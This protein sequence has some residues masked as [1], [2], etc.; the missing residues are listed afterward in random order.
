MSE[1]FCQDLC[2]KEK[3]E[4]LE[5]NIV[6][7]NG[8]VSNLVNTVNQLLI[9][10]DSLENQ[11]NNHIDTKVNSDSSLAH[12]YD[13]N[14]LLNLDIKEEQFY[15]IITSR[16]TLEGESKE[17]EII[18]DKDNDEF[19]LNAVISGKQLY[20]SLYQQGLDT[21]IAT[22]DLPF[23]Y[24]S[25]FDAHLNTNVNGQSDFAHK[26]IPVVSVQ[27]NLYD[28]ND[29][30][31]LTTKV[32]I[33]LEFDQDNVSLPKS[34]NEINIDGSV[35]GK[36]LYLT[37]AT[38]ND[39]DTATI[40]LPIEEEVTNIFNNFGGDMECDLSPVLI[41]ID[42]CCEQL[43]TEIDNNQALIE[44]V[45]YKLDLRTG[46]L[47]TLSELISTKLDF[48]FSGAAL[49]NLTCDFPRDEDDEIIPT[50]AAS[51]YDSIPY[52]FTG[53]QGIHELL[54][55][56]INNQTIIQATACKAVSPPVTVNLDDFLDN[57]CAEEPLK[58]EEDFEELELFFDYIK[59]I[60][61]ERLD[62]SVTKLLLKRLGSFAGVAGF[63][64]ST[65]LDWAIGH[66]ID[67]ALESQNRGL[68]QICE[69]IKE[70]SNDEV[71]AIIASHRDIPRIEGKKLI[72]HFVSLD[73]YPKR[74]QNTSY[75]AVQVPSPIDNESL[76]WAT[77]F[78]NIRWVQG[79]LYCELSL[80]DENGILYK[81][82]I[83]GFFRDEA[84]ADN[85]FNKFLE[86]TTL[87]EA[88]RIY[89][90]RTVSARNILEIE[91]RPYRAF[92]TYVNDNA[93]AI[94]ELKLRPLEEN[95][96]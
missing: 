48:E 29:I 38:Q 61:L 80:K 59:E 7:L 50:Y 54:K 33:D 68:K 13:P 34:N 23:T 73:N 16:L 21:D 86:L 28:E 47:Q 53:F 92:V 55:A 25:D 22:V 56:I 91:T 31:T 90:K 41:A 88:S 40:Y 75:R 49:T 5:N 32:Q 64:V 84:A 8:I 20:I 82:S 76:D 69:A 27:T 2:T 9:Q 14:F 45:D 26:Y 6:Y 35:A 18:L 3:C 63:T 57:L 39:T 79:N 72:L 65:T 51:S 81:P 60:L 43:K 71:V 95:E 12:Q 94:C 4:Q 44:A 96:E 37:V 17:D 83:S 67:K 93:Q 30:Y 85:T 77:H 66:L 62:E 42:T 46:E 78:E 24:Q 15:Y 74:K 1:L 10:V 58:N 87:Q 89:H 19:D 52:N 11:L 36:Y 70:P